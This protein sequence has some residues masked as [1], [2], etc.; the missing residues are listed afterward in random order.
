MA[1]KDE[2]PYEI[3]DIVDYEGDSF[4]VTVRWNDNGQVVNYNFNDKLLE[5]EKFIDELDRIAL[6][7]KPVENKR[8]KIKALKDK[9]IK[10]K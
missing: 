1:K 6:F 7:R 3:L 4:G 8:D 2:K 5:D 9:H 10:N